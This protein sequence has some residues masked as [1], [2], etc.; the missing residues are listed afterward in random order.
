MTDTILIPKEIVIDYLGDYDLLTRNQLETVIL[1][2]D[3]DIEAI[4]ITTAV[5]FPFPEVS[6]VRVFIAGAL[7]DVDLLDFKDD[8]PGNLDHYSQRATQPYLIP[9]LDPECSNDYNPDY[10]LNLFTDEPRAS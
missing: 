4:A 3:E 5:Y 6:D 2:E 10:D 9:E 1:F 7:L 8:T